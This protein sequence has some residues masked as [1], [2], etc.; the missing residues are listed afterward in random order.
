MNSIIWFPIEC[1]F[2][3]GFGIITFLQFPD[4][5]TELSA[6]DYAYKQLQHL[7][8][9]W[10]RR[11]EQKLDLKNKARCSP[12][13][14]AWRF[15]QFSFVSD[16][17]HYQFFDC[18]QTNGCKITCPHPIRDLVLSWVQM[19][20][21]QFDKPNGFDKDR[22]LFRFLVDCSSCLPQLVC[23]ISSCNECL[24]FRREKQ[25]VHLVCE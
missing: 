7:S 4:C 21:K 5:R 15:V 11:D 8:S 22:L 25:F 19:F 12:C 2:S 3:R 20:S 6:T 17:F 10:N 9:A 24:F 1:S 14:N 16:K 18:V 13:S 23:D